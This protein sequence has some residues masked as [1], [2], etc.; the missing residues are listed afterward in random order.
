MQPTATINN[1]YV[2]LGSLGGGGMAQVFLAHDELLERDVAL[3]VL[4]DQ[5]AENEEFVERFRREALSVASLSHPNIVQVYDRGTSEDGRYYIAMEYVPGGTLKERIVGDGNLSPG[6]A[7]AVAAQVADALGAAHERGVIHRDVKPQNVLVD[8]SGDVKVADFG[9]ARAAAAS[10][11]SETSAVLGTAVYMSPEQ[12][13]GQEVGPPSDLYSLGVVLYEML[14]GEVPFEADTPVAI[15][16]KQVHEPPRPPKEIRGEIPEEVNAV[17]LKLLAKEPGA[18]YASAAEL[19]ADLDR[20]AG[21]VP[22]VAGAGQEAPTEPF[23]PAPVADG[24]DGGARHR[25]SR[26]IAIPIALAL[27]LGTVGWAI[28]AG[29]NIG[30]IVGS[31]EGAADGARQ[32]AKELKDTVDPPTQVAVPDVEELDEEAARRRLDE[33]GLGTV[34]RER[35]SDE[36]EAGQVLEQ[37]VP[38]GKKV[39]EGSRVLLA[40]S[41][42]PGPAAQQGSAPDP[43]AGDQAED[44]GEADDSGTTPEPPNA[45][46]YG[47]SD[48]GADASPAPEPAP[49]TPSGA[50][51]GVNGAPPASPEPSSSEVPAP[52]PS[53][54]GSSAPEPASPAPSSPDPSSP[55]PTSPE[56]SSPAPSSPAPSSPA[57]SSPE[58]ASPAPSSPEPS[59]S[60]DSSASPDAES[61]PTGSPS[62]EDG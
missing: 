7:A 38:A 58:P 4:R 8:A 55:T 54:P 9:I 14:T 32:E 49:G 35:R 34:V 56:P 20:V 60:P 3:K 61:D 21:G 10:V 50:G 53:S 39:E 41:S 44:S 48:P 40:I 19:V 59:D 33:A 22:P 45:G 18:R 6:T 2:V 1:R 16:M 51:Q 28:G 43:A 31:L 24:Q 36:E 5:Y 25:R 17:V 13:M 29:P 46:D 27:V 37:S 26:W 62:P 23:R 30:Q 57:P 47:G 52:A 11:I 12:A 42:G 15:S